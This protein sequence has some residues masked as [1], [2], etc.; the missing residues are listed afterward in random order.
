MSWKTIAAG[1]IGVLSLTS[2]LAQDSTASSSIDWQPQC[3]SKG[4]H[5][6]M[7]C[8]AQAVQVLPS[9][10][11]TATLVLSIQENGADLNAVLPLGLN[12]PEGITYAVDH[13]A[14]SPMALRTCLP[15]GCVL[16]THLTSA[17]LNK[18]KSSSVFSLSAHVGGQLV[19][20]DFPMDKFAGVFEQIR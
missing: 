12:L 11:L 15:Q 4:R 14:E 10:K 8:S 7:Q 1:L 19:K 18:L 17:A 9:T 6:P 3:T 5:A 20:F 13:G 16:V 2:A